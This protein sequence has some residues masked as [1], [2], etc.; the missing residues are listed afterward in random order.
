[1]DEEVVEGGSFWHKE[2]AHGQR[3]AG[4]WPT[5]SGGVD[6]GEAETVTKWRG[7]R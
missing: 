4:K 7:G 1:M 5:R 6:Q 3:E 2:V